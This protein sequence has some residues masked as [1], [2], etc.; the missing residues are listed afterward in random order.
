MLIRIVK[1]S[2]QED[3]I[4]LFLAEFEQYKTKIRA[5]KGCNF[6]ELHRD[7]E[8]PTTFFTYSYWDSEN[9]LNFYRNS[10]LFKEV[11]SKTKILFNQK[12]QAWSV[13]TIVSLQ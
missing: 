3:Q 9:D 13:E 2:F 8:I 5:V 4:S 6:L 7:I 12:P 10:E 11:W 1:M